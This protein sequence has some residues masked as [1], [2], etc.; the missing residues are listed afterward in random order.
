MVDYKKI[1][2]EDYGIKWDRKKFQVH[3][4]D[5]DRS[6]ND[7]TNLILVPQDLHHRMHIFVD[8][9]QMKFHGEDT[10]S[11][12]M[13]RVMRDYCYGNISMLAD[14]INNILLV[15]EEFEK[16]GFYKYNRY[17][18]AYGNPVN[19]EGIWKDR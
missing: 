7:L 19:I 11:E 14:S 9:I 5:H 6:N 10:L 12:A 15:A 1:D 8:D 13:K 3:H 16:W 2:E 4:I 17:L 18:D